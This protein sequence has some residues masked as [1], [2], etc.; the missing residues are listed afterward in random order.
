MISEIR[1]R[2]ARCI[3]TFRF[4]HQSEAGLPA[5]ARTLR[6]IKPAFALR[7]TAGSLYPPL[8]SGRRLE[9]VA[10]SPYRIRS[11]VPVFCGFSS[12]K[13]EQA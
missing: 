7:A 4:S 13:C 9:V 12:L 8:R 11:P 3:G 1:G 5:V 10:T 6:A 2:P